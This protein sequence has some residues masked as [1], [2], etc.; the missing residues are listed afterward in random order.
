MKTLYLGMA[1]A[2]LLNAIPCLY[3]AA[4]GP[5]V[6]DTVIAI[7]MLNTMTVVI[8]L[9][10]SSFFELEIFTD[11]SFMFAFLYFVL[12]YGTSRYI[13]ALGGGFGSIDH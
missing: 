5:R 1:I 8:M 4:R 13:E 3:Q 11:I 10:L 2:L 6:Q 9:L 12:V 7:N